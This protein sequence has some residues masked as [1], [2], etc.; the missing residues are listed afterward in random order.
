MQ[1]I[2]AGIDAFLL[3]PIEKSKVF[4]AIERVIKILIAQK[5][6][7]EEQK[8]HVSLL[9]QRVAYSDY[10]EKLSFQKSFLK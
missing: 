5:N 3:K 1:A 9:T 6:I 2:E 7:E 10:H 8:R 4:E